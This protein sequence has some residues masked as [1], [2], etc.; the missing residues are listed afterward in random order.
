MDTVSLNKDADII[1]NAISAYQQDEKATAES[2]TSKINAFIKNYT[3]AI[4]NSEQKRANNLLGRLSDPKTKESTCKDLAA[5]INTVAHPPQGYFQSFKGAIIGLISYVTGTIWQQPLTPREEPL[6]PESKQYLKSLLKQWGE[7]DENINKCKLDQEAVRFD[8]AKRMA[9]NDPSTLIYKI[10]DFQLSEENRFKV[11]ESIICTDTKF[12]VGALCAITNIDKFEL[13]YQ[14]RFEI[15]SKANNDMVCVHIEKFDLNDM[16]RLAIAK[17]IA[18]EGSNMLAIHVEKFKISRE[19]DRFD[20]AFSLTKKN[21]YLFFLSRIMDFVLTQEHRSQI[22]MFLAENEQNVPSL[23]WSIK[24]FDLT[25]ES[26]V[27]IAKAAAKSNSVIN[28]IRIKNFEIPAESDRV[29]IAKSCATKIEYQDTD[30]RLK[31][32]DYDI[33]NEDSRFEVALIHATNKNGLISQ[34]IDSYKITSEHKRFEIA[35]AAALT[36]SSMLLKN[37]SNFAISNK[38]YI[39]EIFKILALQEQGLPLSQYFSKDERLEI[40]EYV[41]K[42][43]G[44]QFAW[45]LKDYDLT[46]IPPDLI[47]STFQNVPEENI[48]LVNR[49]F[50][51]RLIKDVYSSKNLNEFVGWAQEK[52]KKNKELNE[53]IIKQ[54]N[55]W[56]G[57]YKTCCK[58]KSLSEAALEKQLPYAKEILAHQDPA[59]RYKLTS[60]LFQYGPPAQL[61]G[62]DHNLLFDILLSPLIKQS[63]LTESEGNQ[64]RKVLAHADYYDSTKREKVL[65]GLHTLLYCE[66]LTAKQK[67]EILQ[68]IFGDK[69]DRKTEKGSKES[70][71]KELTARKEEVIPVHNS[72]QLLDAIISSGNVAML[73]ATSET[74]LKETDEKHAAAKDIDRPLKTPINLEET[75]NNA[76]KSIL[77]IKSIEDFGQKYASSIGAAR[78]PMAL[79]VYSIKLGSL[80]GIDRQNALNSLREFASAVLQGT[81]K[82]WRYATPDGSH[83]ETLFKENPLLKLEWQMG[84]KLTLGELQKIA[85]GEEPDI[86][87]ESAA[88]AIDD[89]PLKTSSQFNIVR[90]LKERTEH[91]KPHT[92]SFL[93]ECLE[94]TDNCKGHLQKLAE[95]NKQN[96]LPK[97]ADYNESTK[98]AF[99]RTLE[100]ALIKL[101]DPKIPPEKKMKDIDDFVLPKLIAIYG[102]TAQIVTDLMLLK[103]YLM[104][105]KEDVTKENIEQ[106]YTIEDTDHWE[107]ML[108]CGT[109]VAGSCQRISGDV[110]YNKCLLGYLADGK[111]RAIV[112]K[113]KNGKI[114]ARRIMRLLWDDHP[115]AN[116]PVL[117]QE[118]LYQNPGVPEQAIKAMDLMFALRAKRLEVSLV[119]NDEDKNGDYPHE[120]TSKGSPAPF[121]YVDAS[122]VGITRGYYNIPADSIRLVQE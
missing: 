103:A 55:D 93:N 46:F 57:V 12:H 112:V 98:A 79:M 44:K 69:I 49:V 106:D 72:F 27:A 85:A 74:T 70:L 120:L 117:F 42:R 50:E 77:G 34:S 26:R 65:R 3:I 64:F 62:K 37:L 71:A 58:A 25:L 6:K 118:R 48:S 15:A 101:L 38:T 122:H 33:K 5:L 53:T 102:G 7:T 110:N 60:A 14:H 66:E 16:D 80:F 19:Q 82:S 86:K 116:K 121:E 83:L 100:Y 47:I 89:N 115:T 17:K 105:K 87:A 9:L 94:H 43:N 61:Q 63:G 68:H 45:N 56:L 81:Y 90:Y 91:L 104:T 36:N 108:L 109:E 52:I 1:I 114:I 28:P 41:A 73:K 40:A 4:P 32:E 22:A 23:A 18:G 54:I 2:V 99:L 8:I 78:N 39:K 107:D 111:N 76:F 59:F 20:I 31:M 11:A 29:E 95:M 97:K 30:S 88:Q 96:P 84:E 75:L 10:M 24:Q 119:T 113:D 35:K 21:G 51:D 92:F 67:G 13:T